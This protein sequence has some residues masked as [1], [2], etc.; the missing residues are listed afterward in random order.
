MSRISAYHLALFVVACL[1][2]AVFAVHVYA[3]GILTFISDVIS[4]SA[5]AASA[6][7]TVQFTLANAVPPSGSIVITLEPD[8]FDIPAAFDYTDVDFAVSTS[9][10]PYY[11]RPVD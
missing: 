9:S 7:H 2:A 10:G 11:D 8:A 1:A 5:P 4:T 3:A 6:T